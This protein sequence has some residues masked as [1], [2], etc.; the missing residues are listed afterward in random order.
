MA[1]EK[2]EVP[3]TETPV[4]DTLPEGDAPFKSTEKVAVA[5][6]KEAAG[7]ETQEISDEAQ[8]IADSVNPGVSKEVE[9]TNEVDE[10][11][12]RPETD[13]EKSHV[14]KRIDELTR[15]KKELE[16]RLSKVEKEQT[17]GKQPEYTP[18]QLKTALK[19]AL[20]D[21]DADL[22]WEIIEYRNKQ[23]EANLIKMYEGEKNKGAQEAQRI[24]SE[25]N[26]TVDAYARYSEEKFPEIYTGSRKDLN[27]RDSQSLL[28]QVAMALYGNNDFYRKQ[29]GGQKLA[30]AD[31]LTQI[32]S[33]KAGKGITSTT[34]KLERKL[35]K[36]KMKNA[37]VSGSSGEEDK[38]APRRKNESERLAEVIAERKQYL[39][40]RS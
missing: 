37:P 8:D 33:K 19:K 27:L 24:Q 3:V 34:K 11:L 36:E 1:I 7:G 13:E 26:E 15:E 38:S 5:P 31:A 23:T 22:A 29:P 18:Q 2:I 17:T 35:I 14:Q 10:I 9:E 25:W 12:K 32:L 21:G 39:D 28:Y 30:V 6:D 16:E 40:E 4:E 20:D